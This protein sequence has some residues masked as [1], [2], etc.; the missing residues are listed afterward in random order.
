MLLLIISGQAVKGSEL[1]QIMSTCDLSLVGA[2]S[3]V[4]VNDI[5]RVVYYRATRCTFQ[6]RLKKQK[7]TTTKKKSFYFGRWNV[8]ALILKYSYI[9]SK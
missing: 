5:K 3:L 8:L 1:D 4:T 6:L 7:V 2:D 9:F